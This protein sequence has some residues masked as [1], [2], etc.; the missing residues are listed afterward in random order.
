[1]ASTTGGKEFQGPGEITGEIVYSSS[2]GGK[3]WKFAFDTFKQGFSPDAA[4]AYTP[5]GSAHFSTMAGPISA[6]QDYF[7]NNLKLLD[8]RSPDGG[9]TWDT[10]VTLPGVQGADRQY[11]TSDNTG[12]KYNGALY[13]GYDWAF[14]FRSV[15]N[16]L[17]MGSNQIYGLSRSPDGGK[18]WDFPA[19]R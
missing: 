13:V 4:C 6:G 3:T 11:M 10:P 18:K 5:D 16:N 7:D 1:A 19:T 15:E 8:Y 9:T 12:G 2:D 14:H 17:L